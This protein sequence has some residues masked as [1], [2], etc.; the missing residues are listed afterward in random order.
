MLRKDWLHMKA[1]KRKMISELM[2]GI[3]NGCG[4]GFGLTIQARNENLMG[5]G[6]L[7]LILNVPAIFQQSALYIGN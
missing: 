1:E 3:M 2:F 7:I 6:Y 5:L 4:V